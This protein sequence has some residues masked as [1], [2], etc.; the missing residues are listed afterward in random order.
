MAYYAG[1]MALVAIIKALRAEVKPFNITVT[2]CEPGFF[3]TPVLSSANG[4]GLSLGTEG[5]IDDIMNPWGSSI[6][7]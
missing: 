6:A 3:R 2:M 4:R 7:G 5:T 1:K